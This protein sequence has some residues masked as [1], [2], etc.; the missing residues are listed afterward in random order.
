MSSL[1]LFLA[2]LGF[3]LFDIDFPVGVPMYVP[4]G[5]TL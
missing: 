4:L 2:L 3:E 5:L 1:S